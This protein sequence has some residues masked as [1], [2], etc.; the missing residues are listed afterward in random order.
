[1]VWF[2]CEVL[3]ENDFGPYKSVKVPMELSSIPNPGGNLLADIN[4]RDRQPY[5]NKSLFSSQAPGQVGTAAR[6][7]FHGP[8]INNWNTALV[9]RLM[10]TERMNLDVRFRG[11][12]PFNHASFNN[13]GGNINS[14]TFGWPPAP[15]TRALHKRL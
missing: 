9:K 4:P 1:M 5:F 11:V 13:P 3:G 7:F 12:Q 2:R 6:R 14:S 10:I 8:G 15:S